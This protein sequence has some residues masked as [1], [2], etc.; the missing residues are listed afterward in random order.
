MVCGKSLLNVSHITLYLQYA[1]MYV[2]FIFC[3]DLVAK[4][5]HLSVAPAKMYHLSVALAKI[6][7]ILVEEPYTYMHA[8]YFIF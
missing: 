8:F 7:R 4:M 6:F 1:C 5:Y 3:L 2:Y